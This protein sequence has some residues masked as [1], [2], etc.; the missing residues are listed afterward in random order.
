MT[1][2]YIT[3]WIMRDY[4]LYATNCMPTIYLSFPFSI[5][6]HSLKQMFLSHLAKHF[7]LDNAYSFHIDCPCSNC[8]SFMHSVNSC[9]QLLYS[10]C[11]EGLLHFIPSHLIVYVTSTCHC[12][13]SCIVFHQL[14][15]IN[16]NCICLVLVSLCCYLF[17][18]LHQSVVT[19]C[20]HCHT[21]WFITLFCTH[22]LLGQQL[23]SRFIK[24]EK[25]LISQ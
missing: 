20:Q 9:T 16:Y 21:R 5:L 12:T 11:L 23:L 25:I 8:V 18:Q 24:L 15:L 17:P 3:V 19:D 4:I 7:D 14:L 6:K 1:A 2:Q 10:D 22:V 13:I